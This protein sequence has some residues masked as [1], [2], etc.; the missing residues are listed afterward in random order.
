M[1]TN[2]CKLSDK[3]QVLL[4]PP[5]AKSPSPQTKK[6]PFKPDL[7]YGL[8]RLFITIVLNISFSVILAFMKIFTHMY[9]TIS[10]IIN[11]HLVF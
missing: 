5:G 4:E 11:I 6:T 2:V 1:L 8:P 9:F 3:A 7:D 10:Q